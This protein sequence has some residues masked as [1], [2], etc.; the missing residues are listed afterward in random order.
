MSIITGCAPTNYVTIE[1]H[2]SRWRWLGKYM[3]NNSMQSKHCV[4]VKGRHMS[5]RK[6]GQHVRRWQQLCNQMSDCNAQLPLKRKAYTIVQSVHSL[7]VQYCDDMVS[8]TI[9]GIITLRKW[10]LKIRDPCVRKMN[11]KTVTTSYV[12][13]IY[14]TCTGPVIKKTSPALRKNIAGNCAAHN[15]NSQLSSETCCPADCK[16]CTQGMTWSVAT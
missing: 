7:V 13:S 5:C 9:C 1:Q 11:T 3:C 14:R 6:N 8:P 15:E 4:D 16:A 10:H 2:V 12:I